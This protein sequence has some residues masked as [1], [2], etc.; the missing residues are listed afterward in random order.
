M[1]GLGRTSQPLRRIEP[2]GPIDPRLADLQRR[3][4]E[5]RANP[6]GAF[7]EASFDAYGLDERWTGLRWVG[8]SGRSDHVAH[9]L[10]LAHGDDP[11]DPTRPLVRVETRLPTV[12]HADPQ[13]NL[14]LEHWTLTRQQ[15][16]SFWHVTGTLPP[17]L[18][19]AAFEPDE[20]PA[21][22]TGPWDP[23]ELAIDAK[24]VE[25]RVLLHEQTWV[26][27]GQRGNLFVGIAAQG[28]ALDDTGLV[29]VGAEDLLAYERGSQQITALRPGRPGTR[30]DSE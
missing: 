23:V 28:W 26:A 5:S 25:F 9:R 17:E 11:Y 10:T 19:A 15:V 20:I 4:H 3:V 7:T 22:P 8:G 30:D 13:Q 6:T 29:T 16:G 14:V 24:P 21:D 18:R 1:R 12:V 2:E 27:Q